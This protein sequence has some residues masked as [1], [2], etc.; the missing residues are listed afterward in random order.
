MMH[1][2]VRVW[3]HA[4]VEM[5]YTNS[6]TFAARAQS[7][8]AGLRSHCEQKVRIAEISG[9]QGMDQRWICGHF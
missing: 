8:H 9:K 4:A 6:E 3:A 2:K 7:S 5:C 1:I